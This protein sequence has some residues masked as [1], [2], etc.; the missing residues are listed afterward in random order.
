[1]TD[2]NI[3]NSTLALQTK[4]DMLAW[5]GI[6]PE[7]Y[8]IEFGIQARTYRKI[9][10]MKDT[11]ESMRFDTRKSIFNLRSTLNEGISIILEKLNG[12]E[13]IE[14]GKC[15]DLRGIMQ[16]LLDDKDIHTIAAKIKDHYGDVAKTIAAGMPGEGGKGHPSPFQVI[17]MAGGDLMELIKMIAGKISPDLPMDSIR[18]MDPSNNPIKNLLTSIFRGDEEVPDKDKLH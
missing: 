7:Q 4:V 1:M 3:H 11:P 12:S 5:I 13:C 14:C 2:V 6:L 10:E 9:L 8:A 18:S 15:D 16:D 17:D